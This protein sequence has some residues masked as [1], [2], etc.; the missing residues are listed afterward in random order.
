MEIRY[1]V[2][3]HP[4]LHFTLHVLTTSMHKLTERLEQLAYRVLGYLLHTRDYR[5]RFASES[6]QLRAYVDASYGI[7][8]R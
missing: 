5:K 3:C 6:L 2:D 8:T 1:L 7:H 4:D